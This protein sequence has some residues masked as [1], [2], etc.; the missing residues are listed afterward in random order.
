MTG[1]LWLSLLCCRS[2]SVSPDLLFHD[3]DGDGVTENNGDC[4]DTSIHIYPG[5]IEY[6]DLM[7]NDCDGEIDE[8]VGMLVFEDLDGD[9][10]GSD[11]SKFACLPSSGWV[12]NNLDCDDANPDIHPNAD[13]VC[14]GIDNDC[15]GALDDQDANLT[16]LLE[17]YLD[18]DGDG[19]GDSEHS[20]LICEAIMGYVAND[21]D[22]NDS[23]A[24]IFPGNPEI[25]DDLDHNCDGVAQAEDCALDFAQADV[26]L[27]G[28]PDSFFGQATIFGGS[29]INGGDSIVISANRADISAEDAGAVF[30]Y[31]TNSFDVEPLETSDATV[32]ITGEH[33]GDFFGMS[34]ATEHPWMS[35]GDSNGDGW[36]DLIVGAP[37]VDGSGTDRGAVYLFEG[38]LNG[39][40]QAGDA[41][42]I[43]MGWSDFGYAGTSV[44][45]LD[46]DANGTADIIVGI[47]EY[48]QIA[49][50][51][52]LVC[53]SFAEGSSALENAEIQIHATRASDY[54]GE[55]VLNAG[56]LNGDGLSDLLISAYRGD[57]IDSRTNA[58]V[59]NAGSIYAFWGGQGIQGQL[60]VEDANLVIHGD[61]VNGYVG[62]QLFQG[63]DINGDGLMDI[64]IGAPNHPSAGSVFVLSGQ[65]DWEDEVWLY[66]ATAR[67]DGE[68]TQDEFGRSA[69][70]LGDINDDGFED[71]MI[72]AKKNSST[73]NNAGAAYLY[74]GPLSGIYSGQ[75][76]GKIAG[77]T[78]NEQSG[79]SMAFAGDIDGNG[80]NDVVVGALLNSING[81]DAGAVYLFFGENFSR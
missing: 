58:E 62:R 12:N 46:F 34:L 23:D 72:G 7:D 81:N 60:N 26:R 53:I 35:D 38:P 65:N 45:L 78:E 67:M 69:T 40:I 52:G 80:V 17:W 11:V 79:V 74:Y 4:D 75:Y 66:D 2:K 37:L 36:A 63:G 3:Y 32:Q 20:Q 64:L 70:R 55:A 76:H 8:D 21:E 25:C 71:I 59:T 41:D 5:A 13:E 48:S 43:F 9:G 28:D 44:D 50:K 19:F 39:S 49:S 42:R 47:P 15:N 22:C 73:L 54:L 14:D 61:I 57:P 68:N 29:L 6:C 56:D 24:S 31:A 27:F 33:S 18:S 16:S 1:F 51:S 30:V 77:I 10:F